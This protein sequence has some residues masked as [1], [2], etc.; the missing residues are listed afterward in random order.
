[1]ARKRLTPFSKILIVVLI[2]GGLYF[3]LNKLRDPAVKDKIEEVTSSDNTSA[4]KDGYKD[5]INVGVVTWGGYAGGQYFNEGFKANTASRF[6]KDYGFKV[7]FEVIDDFDASRDA[8]K[9]GS[10]DLMWATIDAFPTEVEGLSQYQ[11]QVVFQADWSRGGDAIVARRGINKVSDLRGKKIAV[12]PMTPSHSFLI[13]L[14]EAGDMS[15]KDVKIVEVPSAIDA[16]DA[17]KS[18]TVDA[19]VVWSPDD[20]DCVSKVAG[21][22]VLESTK[23]ATHIIADVFVAK[24]EFIETHKDQLKDLYKGWM[25]GASELNN[26]ESNKRKA[27]KILAEGLSQPEDF[28]FDAINNV[29][30]A[31]HGDNQSF[32]GLNSNYN[33]VTG[34]DLY[35]K[36]KV[37][38]NNL[39][40]STAGAKSWRLLSTK[41]LVS[42]TSLSGSSHDSEKQKE[43]TVVDDNLAKKESLSSKKVS[44]SFRTGEFRLGENAKQLID[45]QFTPI[46]KAF[47]NTRIRIEG[48]TDNVGN[49]NSNIALSKKRAQSVADYLINEHNMPVNRFIIL[50]NGPD[51]PIVGCE[52][53]QNADCKSKNRRTDFELVV[54]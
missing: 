49:R 36:M 19:A 30:L 46:A 14:L 4:T 48:N 23:N 42:K 9:N 12:A 31:T 22:K 6:Y 45:L 7:N 17:F 21:S 54:D 32:F 16:A 40:Y 38:Y 27:A 2:I 13:W 25:I 52:R 33:G 47:A 35:N 20:A 29:R 18:N 43:F 28:C 51:K 26:S 37:K 39:G 41:D 3:L 44:I 5:V 15:T 1:M 11:P 8:F 50:G 10:I 24:K 34:E 53:N